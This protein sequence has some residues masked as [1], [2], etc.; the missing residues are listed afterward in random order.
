MILLDTHAWLWWVARD[1]QLSASAVAAITADSRPS[2]AAITLWEVVML[3]EKGRVQLNLNLAEW[4]RMATSGSGVAIL[5][6]TTEI[7]ARTTRLGADFHGDPAD[8]LIV[9]HGAGARSDGHHQRRPH[10]AERAGRDSVVAA[11]FFSTAATPG[12]WSRP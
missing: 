9:G 3:L 12:G 7:A 10:T 4:L 6:I 1:A 8:R 2:I 11:Y 5:P